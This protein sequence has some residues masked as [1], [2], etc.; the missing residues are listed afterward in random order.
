MAAVSVTM[1]GVAKGMVQDDKMQPS[2]SGLS[3][4]RSGDGLGKS[5]G[6]FTSKTGVHIVDTC[7]VTKYTGPGDK[8]ICRQTYAATFPDWKVEAST[9]GS[10]Q[11]SYSPSGIRR[12]GG[13]TRRSQ[14]STQQPPASFARRPRRPACHCHQRPVAHLLCLERWRRL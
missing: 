1:T 4:G 12:F 11:Q 6:R 9:S 2:R 7:H 3:C 8:D 5:Y 14:S 10:H 13:E